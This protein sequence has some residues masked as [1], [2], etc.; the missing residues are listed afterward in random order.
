MT[1]GAGT[2]GRETD[3]SRS[4]GGESARPSAPP[5]ATTSPSVGFFL[6]AAGVVGAAAAAFGVIV[7]PGLRGNAGEAA[8]NRWDLISSVFSYAMALLLLGLLA[9]GAGGLLFSQPR[10]F[11]APLRTPAVVGSAVAFMLGIAAFWARFPAPVTAI[12][13]T[14]T[15]LGVLAAGL[16]SLR[17]P[18]TRA[19][20][21]V[22]VALALAGTTRLIA[23]EVAKVAG[24]RASTGIYATSRS[25]ATVGVVFEG[26]A[27]LVSA[28]W[29]GTR[30]R[31][32]GQFLSSVAIAVAFILTWGVAQG[33]HV[34]AALWQAILHTALADAAGTPPPFGLGA[35]ATFLVPVS[36]LLA[37]VAAVQPKQLGVVVG[38]LALSLLSRGAYDA[39][40][41]ALAAMTAAVWTMAASVDDRAFWK[42][43]GPVRSNDAP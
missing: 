28:V 5:M 24:E 26:L 8:V 41:R 18:H 22:L 31:F 29:L 12:L 32:A 38:A 43:L 39:P 17:A 35:V 14:A 33:V 4:R 6:R 2:A 15:S 10:R 21:V 9:W 37:L 36:M 40:L 27:Q 30:A 1:Q 42:L 11:R 16:G 19:L 23:W 13:A 20:A 25:L 34:G 3:A 7:A